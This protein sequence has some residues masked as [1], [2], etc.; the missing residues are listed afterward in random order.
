MSLS[1]LNDVMG[2]GLNDVMGLGLN[3]VI[4]LCST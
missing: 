1:W 2:L 4:S 3:D